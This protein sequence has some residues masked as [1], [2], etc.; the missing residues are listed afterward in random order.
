MSHPGS[1]FVLLS[2]CWVLAL[3][4]ALV[5][6]ASAFCRL[7]LL[8]WGKGERTSSIWVDRGMVCVADPTGDCVYLLTGTT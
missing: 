8:V 2:D 3:H 1:V 7:W 5:C 4:C 6:R